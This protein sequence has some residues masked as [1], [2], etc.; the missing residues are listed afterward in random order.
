[1]SHRFGCFG[2]HVYAVQKKAWMDKRV[3]AFYLRSLLHDYIS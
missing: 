1:M 3:W 2:G